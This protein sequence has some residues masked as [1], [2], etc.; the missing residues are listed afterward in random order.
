M[1]DPNMPTTESG[2]TTEPGI[3]ATFTPTPTDEVAALITDTNT[4]TL[5]STRTPTFTVTASATSTAS[6]TASR[7]PTFTATPSATVTSSP[8]LTN[9][10]TPTVTSTRTPTFTVTPSQTATS[11]P[12]LPPTFTPSPTVTPALGVTK[13]TD[14]AGFDII[15][16]NT[17]PNAAN[18]VQI[19]EALR[20]GV[21]YLSSRPGAPVCIED[22]GIVFCALG[23]IGSGGSAVVDV[24]VVTDGSDPTSGRT[25]VTSDGVQLL[26]I[27]EPYLLK[28]GDPPIA[29]PGT[30]VT[31]TLRVINP[32]TEM[33]A[34][35]EV[36][37][38][39][40]DVLTIVEATASS[41]QVAINGQN[42]IF[43]QDKLEAGGR[44][45]IIV[46]TRVR[47]TGN[48][49]EIVNEACLTSQSN[50][51][52]SCAHMRFLRAG[53][54]PSTGEPP[55]YRLWL[56]PLLIGLVLLIGCGLL[57]RRAN[58]L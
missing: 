2:P 22:E 51:T 54:I 16:E 45:T 5:T 3:T 56:L 19:V 34:Q 57:I 50:R 31:Y 21:R 1:N 37:D 43:T 52:P 26:I 27:D 4:P 23:T 38:S 12:T 8:T 55:A 41:G 7:T 25:I 35:V 48:Y 10:A 58:Q 36:A 24:D 20:P 40:P 39:L 9:T 18:N 47:E 11:S 44:A 30:I 33:A 6:A 15:I 29:A 17:G 42:V 46:I 28:I 13:A 53:E 32:T 49:D 14:E